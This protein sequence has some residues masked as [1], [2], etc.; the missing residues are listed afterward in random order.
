ME[1]LIDDEVKAVAEF[2]H[3]HLP[4]SKLV[5]TANAH[6]TSIR[7]GEWLPAHT[8]PLRPREGGCDDVA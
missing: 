7:A 5:A 3:A 2:M 4:A 8:A 1:L 6:G